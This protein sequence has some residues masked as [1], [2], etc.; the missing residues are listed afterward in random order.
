[1]EYD[2]VNPLA[3]SSAMESMSSSPFKIVRRWSTPSAPNI[4]IHKLYSQSDQWFYGHRC[5]HCNHLNEMKYKDYNPDN[6]EESGNVLLLNPEGIDEQAKTV[7]DGTYQFVCQKCGKPL[8][9]WYNGEW[10]C[11]YPERT[12]GNKGIRGYLITQM[13]AVWISLDELKEKE[14]NTESKQS[15]HNYILGLPYEDVK[16][17]VLEE[18]VFENKSPIA[19]EQLFDRGQYQFISVGIDWG[20]IHWVTVHGMLPDG[21][22]DL[23]RLFPVKKITI[24][25]MVESD[26]SQI[27]LEISK[28]NPDII[29]ADNGDSGNNILKLINHFGADKVFGCT[30]KSSPRSTG[31]LRPEFNE[32]SNRVTVDKLMQNKRYIQAMKTKEIRMYQKID[33]D[34][35]LFLTHWQNVVIMDE[36]DEKTGE[37]YQIIKRRGDDH[38]SQSAVYSFIG[39]NRLKDLMANNSGSK[40]ESTFLPTDYTDNNQTFHLE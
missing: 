7:K 24:P 35:R 33:N 11:K 18:D 34:L 16:M 25:G 17:R 13:N 40:F 39:I 14:M 22:V 12:K 20:S 5:E 10:H 36:E 21:K 1:M 19:K 38:Y 23:I 4:G 26:L 6:L 32:S 30:Y 9:R 3:E 27:I 15:F 8:D 28:Y 2:R 37:F 29:I 31:Q